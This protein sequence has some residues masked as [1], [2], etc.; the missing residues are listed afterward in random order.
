MSMVKR[1]FLFLLTNLAV[2]I[3]INVILIVLSK[4][5]G[6]NISWYGYGYTSI[7]IFAAVVGFSGSFISLFL[8]KWSAKK[9]YGIQLITPEML[10]NISKKQELVYNIV[11]DISNKNGIKTPEIWIYNSQS[12]NAF[13]TGASKNNSLVAVSTGLLDT[14]TEREVEWVVAHEMAHILNGDMVTMTLLQWVINTFVIF[15]S[16]LAANAV[17]S[18]FSK[19]ESSWPSFIYYA[20]AIFFDIVFG[21]FA[22]IIV[23]WFSRYREYRAD[24]GSARFVWKEKMIAAL[25]ALQ[26]SHI[27]K[28]VSEK[29]AAMQIATPKKSGWKTLFSSHPALEKRIENLE[30]MR[31]I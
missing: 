18:Y 24:E 4:V 31:M 17:D 25:E 14:M 15:F 9:A 10:G 26:K 5:F 30:N 20:T 8:S 23:M 2:L 3:L 29:Y 12:P 16:R 22:S 28:P 1:I 6:I 13:A 21:L 11:L 7:L 27:N 19:W